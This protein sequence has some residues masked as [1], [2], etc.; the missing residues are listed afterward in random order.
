MQMTKLNFNTGRGPFTTEPTKYNFIAV[1][2]TALKF[3]QTVG[4]LMK[5]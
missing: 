2:I 1:R 5:F 4:A 3:C